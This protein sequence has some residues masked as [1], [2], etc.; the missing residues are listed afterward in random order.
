MKEDGNERQAA[1]SP[2]KIAEAELLSVSGPAAIP[3]ASSL[4]QPA[5]VESEA[6]RGRLELERMA[7]MQQI[8]LI[9]GEINALKRRR[10]DLLKI[11]YAVDVAIVAL[12]GEREQEITEL[13][14]S[15]GEKL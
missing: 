12:D 5:L 14:E 7:A 4:S 11:V 3:L 8:E 2:S 15:V 1:R 9:E 6:L 10:G 13:T